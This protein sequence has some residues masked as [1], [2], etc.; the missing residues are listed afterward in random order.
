MKKYTYYFILFIYT[1]LSIH[2]G[3]LASKRTSDLDI[4][5]E[6]RDRKHT[7]LDSNAQ[8]ASEV[9]ISSVLLTQSSSVPQFSNEPLTEEE[10][11]ILKERLIALDAGGDYA[12]PTTDSGFKHLLAFEKGNEKTIISFLNSFV[13]AFA[14]DP[15]ISVSAA[16]TAI[17]S[18]PFSSLKQT[19]MDF[20]VVSQD[21]VHY[22]VEMQAKEHVHFDERALFYACATY[23]SQI[24]EKKFKDKTWYLSLKPVIGL[25]V[26]DYDTNRVRGITGEIP[27]ILIDRVKSNPLPDNEFMKH[28]LMTCQRSGQKINDLQLI[29]IELGRVKK[30]LFPPA[31]DFTEL[32]WWLSTFKYAGKYT[33]E[34]IQ[35]LQEEGIEMPDSIK[36]GFE[37]LRYSKWNPKEIR[38]YKSD[39]IDRE[40]NSVFL[41]VE[42]AEG[43]QEG[44]EE[45]ELI[46]IE[47][48]RLEGQKQQA[49]SIALWMIGK[50]MVDADI[51]EATGL[52]A[53]QLQ[54]LK[55]K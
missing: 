36:A 22:I 48:G 19:F 25:Q 37:R 30:E 17:P 34:Y 42:R 7:K 38:E 49:E 24:E 28:Y 35:A 20:H 27:D 51:I 6:E 3:C 15:V 50:G 16:P 26:L 4:S 18:L 5:G 11:K 29:Q 32:D 55:D 43:K 46:G 39:V 12:I 47:K 13:P 23:S 1:F 52:T 10:N 44:L 40:D 14:H 9:Q 54:T 2:A 31:K 8:A 21:G 33:E 53:E 45:G 41:A